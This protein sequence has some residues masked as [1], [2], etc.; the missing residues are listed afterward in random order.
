MGKGEA[1]ELEAGGRT[2]RLSNPGK[3]YFP[4]FGYTKLDVANYYLAVADGITRALR[5]RPTTLE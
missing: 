1:I 2:V 3:V 4:E 5:D